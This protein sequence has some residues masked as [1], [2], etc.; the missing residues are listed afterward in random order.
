MSD[1]GRQ[2][3]GH[4]PHWVRRTGHALRPDPSRVLAMIFLPG[5][6]ML[7]TGLSRSTSVLGRVLAIP[8]AEVDAELRLL[9][10]AFAHRHRDLTST[11]DA[12]FELVK[13]RLPGTPTLSAGRRRLIG[14]CFTQEFAIE[15]AAL[16]NPSMVPHPDQGGLPPG[17]TR[18]VMTVRA[19]GEGHVSSIELRTG[20]V[21]AGGAISMD[22]PPSVAVQADL[23]PVTYSRSVFRHRLDDLNGDR[24]NSDFVLG[25]LAPEFGRPELDLALG[26]LREESLTRGL[27][28]R[29][30]DQIDQ[31]A[32]CMYSVAFPAGSSIQERVLTPRGPTESHGLEDARMVLFTYPDGSSE[33]LGTYCAFDGSSIS[34]QL[35][36]TV[37]FVHFSMTPLSG[38]GAKDKGLALFPRQVGGRYLAM[39]RADRE[40]NAVSASVD[41]QH[42]DEPVVVQRPE[43]AWELVQLGNC[44]PPI[45]TEAGWL[46]LT[47]G[48]GPMRT[49]GIGAVL[50]DLEDPTVVLGT[51]ARPLLTATG[52]ERSGYVPNVVYSCGAMLH[53]RTLVLPYGCSDSLTRIALVELDALFAELRPA[54]A[55][56][57][58]ADPMQDR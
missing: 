24:T 32:G 52:P 58:R 25:E 11:W 50:L 22:A 37:D 2:G 39:S 30:L 47:H 48:V 19:L 44:G 41:L 57:D 20:V 6:E 38:P 53:G 27:A 43:E 9:S 17:A 34:L 51:L 29:T 5:Q 35:M 55:P 31:V 10:A 46:V 26:V 21:D 8:E 42:W 7:A 23:V 3:S 14:A 28:V 4:D 56:G 45:E 40:D 33:Y 13:H 54:R 15:G 18:F 12:H 49:Y 1:G 16:F 36:R